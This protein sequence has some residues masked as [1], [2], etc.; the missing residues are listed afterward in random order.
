MLALL[1][2]ASALALLLLPA[3]S[4]FWAGVKVNSVQSRLAKLGRSRHG[5]WGLYMQSEQS[6]GEFES[7][8]AR[9]SVD[10]GPR[11][12]GIA[13][14]DLFGVVRPSFTLYNR[15]D[16]SVLSREIVNLARKD[17]CS[18][19]VVGL[20]TD[21]NGKMSFKTRNFNGQ[22]CIS[23]SA[24]L[25]SI[26][27]NEVPG[28]ISGKNRMRVLLVDERYTTREAK[29]RMKYSSATGEKYLKK[30]SVDAVAAAVREYKGI[31]VRLS[32]GENGT[33]NFYICTNHSK[34]IQFL[35]IPIP[36]PIPCSYLRVHLLISTNIYLH[37]YL[38]LC[39]VYLNG[40]WRTRGQ[41]HC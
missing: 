1:F 9:L 36:V 12:V 4:K 13:G 14:S 16:L 11:L 7:F 22:M 6:E 32:E 31:E 23:F 28:N 33:L 20:P 25:A 10:Y 24:V 15:G 19:I 30:A 21:S 18:E 40:I 5:S 38:Y 41:G 2:I 35:P 27:N 26:C 34:L 3:F 39:S 17:G 29:A 8:R 37:L